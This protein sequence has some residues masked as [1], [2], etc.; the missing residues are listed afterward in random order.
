MDQQLVSYI[1]QQLK[2]G[3]DINSIQNFLIQQGYPQKDVSEAAGFVNRQRLSSLADYA[4]VSLSRGIDPDTIKSQLLASGYLI[5]DINQALSDAQTTHKPLPAKTIL[6][7]LVA[8][9]I[10]GLGLFFFWPSGKAGD[11]TRPDI[12]EENNTA[13]TTP[14]VSFDTEPTVSFDDEETEPAGG[15]EREQIKEEPF[16]EAPAKEKTNAEEFSAETSDFDSL[17]ERASKETDVDSAL[18]MCNGEKNS[19]YRDACYDQLSKTFES[20]AICA[21]MEDETVRDQ[22][23]LRIVLKNK[24]YTLCSSIADQSLKESC[25][26]MQSTAPAK[27]TTMDSFSDWTV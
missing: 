9:V 1:Q 26:T 22:C 4:R 18:K 27:N 6:I 15:Y 17:I 5:Q 11:T 7:V 25:I 8:L 3:Y 21:K 12:I 13:G 16:P 19:M 10:F 2:N 14:A 20:S 23:Y 24:D